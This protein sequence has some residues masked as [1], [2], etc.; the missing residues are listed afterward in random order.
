MTWIVLDVIETIKIY[1]KQTSM[2]LSHYENPNLLQKYRFYLKLS[3]F[4]QINRCF[5]AFLE[6]LL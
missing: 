5:I 1:S 6:F 2:G 3:H 4:W